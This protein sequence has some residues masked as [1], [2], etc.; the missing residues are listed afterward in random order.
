MWHAVIWLAAALVLASAEV[1][2]GEFVLLMLGGGA[3]AAGVGAVLGLDVVGSALV[4]VIAS[5][6]LVF[7][8]RPPLRRRLD[9]A[10]ANAGAL[11]SNALIGKTAVVVSRVDD[12]NGQVK[13]GGDL[14]TARPLEAGH[15]IEVGQTVIVM[16]I[17]GA[18][19]LV[20]PED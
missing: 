6:L 19:A 9:R 18:T 8:V 1:L 4:F 14:W 5:V 17:S 10:T 11:H 2:S 15:T 20:V 16:K 12:H 13:I 7:A 3:L